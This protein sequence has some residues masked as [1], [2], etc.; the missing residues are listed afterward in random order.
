MKRIICLFFI[1]NVPVSYATCFANDEY[2]MVLQKLNEFN[3]GLYQDYGSDNFANIVDC[4]N[5]S[6][7][8]SLVCNNKE[9]ENAMLLLSKGE[10]YTYEN[11]T[12]KPLL[13]LNYNIPFRDGLNG[14]L[15]KEIDK[16]IALRKL[17]YI[18]KNKLSDDL[19]NDFY[20]EPKIHEVMSSKINQN[21][22]VVNALDTI[23][24]L[25]KSCDA[26]VLSYK[27]IKSIWHNDGDQFVISQ[28]NKDGNFEEKYRF[29]YDEN[30]AKLNCN[31][32]MN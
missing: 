11:A 3:Q 27:D 23:I 26:V 18:V 12:K 9:L 14:I 15:K 10:I 32:P 29:N 8:A 6:V 19:G 1:L 24:Y 31:K 17:C 28:P 20:Y 22:V 2:N 21:G 13:N 16:N 4:K 30:V 5:T 7:L 25:G